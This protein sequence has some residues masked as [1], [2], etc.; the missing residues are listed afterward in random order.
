MKH[1]GKRPTKRTI[2][3]EL[4]RKALDTSDN[5]SLDLLFTLYEQRVKSLGEGPTRSQETSIELFD[6]RLEATNPDIHTALREMYFHDIRSHPDRLE[7]LS[8][9]EHLDPDT[10]L[11]AIKMMRT[12]A[13]LLPQATPPTS[14][15]STPTKRKAA[16]WMAPDTI[17][18]RPFQ[19]FEPMLGMSTTILEPHEHETTRDW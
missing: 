14:T 4:E 8:D 6:K 9:L 7:S 5:N 18:Q 19:S 10:Y 1:F 17:P 15:H 3:A 13:A 12:R 2:A 11:R 16:D